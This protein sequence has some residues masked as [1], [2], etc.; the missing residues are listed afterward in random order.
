MKNLKTCEVCRNEYNN[1]FEVVMD[2]KA[3]YFDCFECAIH[4]LAPVCH[5]CNV[6]LLGH[7]LEDRGWLYCSHACSRAD[8]RNQWDAARVVAL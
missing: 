8:W 2:E 1:C 4:A 5:H 3:H 7:G 6:K